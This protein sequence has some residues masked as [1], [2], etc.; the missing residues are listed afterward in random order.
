MKNI[1]L[2]LLCALS[3]DIMAQMKLNNNTVS[4]DATGDIKYNFLHAVGSADSLTAFSIGGTQNVYYKVNTGGAMSWHECDG[5]TCAADS[6]KV[7][8]AGDYLIMPVLSITTSNANDVL[9]IKLYKNGAPLSTSIG[10]WIVNSQGTGLG[11]ARCFFWYVTLSVNDYLSIRI[12]NQT[13]SR[14][15]TV[16]DFKFYIEKKPE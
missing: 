14:A 4:I 15:I 1:F 16:N 12:T 8:T 9:R 2:I 10:R 5:F 6:I 3:F 13:A 7:L 11:S